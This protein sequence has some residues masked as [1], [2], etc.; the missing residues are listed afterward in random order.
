MCL[1]VYFFIALHALLLLS[2]SNS[3]TLRKESYV[4]KLLL[5][6]YNLKPLSVHCKVVKGITFFRFTLFLWRH[7]E[8]SRQ[9]TPKLNQNYYLNQE[10]SLLLNQENFV[11]HFTT[12]DGLNRLNGLKGAV[13]KNLQLANAGA[14][15]ATG[16][17]WSKRTQGVL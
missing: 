3:I 5:R 1:F 4:G 15:G 8:K 7:G 6:P 10:K 12:F 17:N 2:P 14:T 9:E 16:A 13:T 11:Q